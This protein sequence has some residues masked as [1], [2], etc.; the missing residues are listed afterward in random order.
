MFAEQLQAYSKNPVALARLHEG[1]KHIQEEGGVTAQ[2]TNTLAGLIHFKDQLRNLAQEKYNIEIPN[3]EFELSDVR[4]PEELP[5][6]ATVIAAYPVKYTIANVIQDAEAMKLTAT[7]EQLAELQVTGKEVIGEP[8][9]LQKIVTNR[10]KDIIIERYNIRTDKDKAVQTFIKNLSTN[11]TQD[12]V[13]RDPET[14]GAIYETISK[15]EKFLDLLVD[16]PDKE[17]IK[18]TDQLLPNVHIQQLWREAKSQTQSGNSNRSSSNTGNRN[19]TV[20]I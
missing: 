14:V 9:K 6:G 20:N 8:E 12:L 18:K 11:I 19:N 2:D 7:P 10:V 3:P 15:D 4:K 1:L 16:M 5:A 13:G 17:L